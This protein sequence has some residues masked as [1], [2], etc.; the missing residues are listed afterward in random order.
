MHADAL[1]PKLGSQVADGA[2]QG[3]LSDAH[4]VVILYDLL[5]AIVGHREKC[6]AVAHKWLRQMRHADKCPA[7][8]VH[9]RQKG[10]SGNIRDPALKRLF[11]RKRDRMHNEI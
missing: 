5:A 6:A 3:S 11:R 2:L 7:R 9:R 1:W 4:D 10:V 8:D